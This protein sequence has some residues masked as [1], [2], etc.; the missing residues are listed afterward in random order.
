MS[1]SYQYQNSKYS[2]ITSMAHPTTESYSSFVLIKCQRAN[3]G[4][5]TYAGELALLGADVHYTSDRYGS[6]FEAW[7]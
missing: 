5:D 2:I 3:D 4:T 7:D 1:A 6:K